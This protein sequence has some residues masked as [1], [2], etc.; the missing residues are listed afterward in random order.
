[1]IWIFKERGV[2]KG[3]ALVTYEDPHCVQKAIKWFTGECALLST[4][5]AAHASKTFF[6]QIRQRFSR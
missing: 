5:I 1:M 4:R 2:P 6:P 3:E